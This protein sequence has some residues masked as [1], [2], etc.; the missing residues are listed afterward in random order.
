V[1]GNWARVR[2][3]AGRAG[4]GTADG[5]AF[6][7]MA[8]GDEAQLLRFAARLGEAWVD[9]GLEIVEWAFG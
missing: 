1:L 4:L 6:A 2:A 3:L 8:N 9:A 7:A 5:S